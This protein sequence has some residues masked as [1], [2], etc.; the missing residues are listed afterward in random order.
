MVAA[1]R[2]RARFV[3]RRNWNPISPAPLVVKDGPIST[4]GLRPTPNHRSSAQF[5]RQ[6][7]CADRAYCLYPLAWTRWTASRFRKCRA[8]RE[9][10]AQP[11][12]T[13]SARA[14]WGSLYARVRGECCGPEKRRGV[15][16]MDLA[17]RLL[18]YGFHAPTVYFPLT[19]PECLMVEPTETES[20]ETLDAFAETLFRVTE[21]SAELLHEAP[22]TTLTSR[23][24]EVR[25]TAARIAMAADIGPGLEVPVVAT[26]ALTT[27]R[28]LIDTASFGPWNMAVDEVLL[29]DA[30]QGQLSLRFYA[31]CPIT[32]SLGYF[33]HVAHRD[34]HHA[35]RDCPL[36]RRASGGGA[37]VHDD[38]QHELT[39]S[40][41][42]PS[43]R[44]A[45]KHHREL[46]DRFHLS[47][48][49]A[50]ARFGVPAHS[51]TPSLTP[52][53]PAPF[54]CFQR[55][56]VGDVMLGD[57]K[58]AGSASGVRGMPYCNMAVSC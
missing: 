9:L 51:C 39:Y 33:Q 7:R 54:L 28:L 1:G 22:H 12:Q 24:D 42:V 18:D 27:G 25:C 5:F 58:I 40:V 11:R 17:K 52:L 15:T 43:P 21:E 26:P 53:A 16:A 3:Y 38:A 23:P 56:T 50:L 34:A 44:L 8:Q 2:E 36:V 4:L 10:F 57:N 13:H 6:R 41:A 55:H 35:S 37:I 46:Y 14:P 32:L 20:R 31:W 47:L 45:R 48:I 29:E 49:Q 30:D 19:V